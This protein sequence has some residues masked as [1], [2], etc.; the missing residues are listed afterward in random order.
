MD[1]L[2][3]CHQGTFHAK[4]PC[5]APLHAAT[6][7]SRRSW[8]VT[9]EVS[10]RGTQR[11]CL[12]EALVRDGPAKRLNQGT[13]GQSVFRGKACSERVACSGAGKAAYVPHMPQTFMLGAVG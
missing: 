9:P 5:T 13:D 2:R 11:S 8:K 10:R 7:L 4:L 12:V 1:P 6:V 3:T